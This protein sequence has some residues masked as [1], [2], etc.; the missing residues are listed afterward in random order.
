M[1]TYG[2]VTKNISL[3]DENSSRDYTHVFIKA[4]VDGPVLGA[5][6]L[7]KNNLL[8]DCHNGQLIPNETYR[9]KSQ[10]QP[11][12]CKLLTAEEAEAQIPKVCCPE[13]LQPLLTEF[14]HI[15]GAQFSKL[16]PKQEGARGDH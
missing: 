16:T 14:K 7:S 5:D 1:K 3:G 15:S 9:R 11:I 6:F 2:A 8:V 4:D 12:I 10:Q 13:Y